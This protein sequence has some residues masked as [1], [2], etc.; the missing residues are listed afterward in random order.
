MT[1]GSVAPR[2]DTAVSPPMNTN[3][4]PCY[5]LTMD[6]VNGAR[7]RNAHQQFAHLPLE[8]KFVIGVPPG[9]QHGSG[10]Y[11][12][13]RNLARMKRSMTPGE[14]SCYHGHRKIWETMLDDGHDMALVFEDDFSVV[15]RPALLHAID[16]ATLIA[17]RWDVVKF[18]DFSTKPVVCSRRVNQ[19]EFVYH[20]YPTSGCVAYLIR[21]AVAAALLQRQAIFRPI[22]EDWSHPWE[23]GLRLLS[24]VPNP[25]TEIAIGLGGSLL[26]ADRKNIRG[27]NRNWLRTIHGNILA[28]EKRIRSRRWQQ[29]MRK[30]LG[31]PSDAPP[32][33]AQQTDRTAA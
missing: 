23:S 20:K 27:T 10:H 1:A 6:P 31:G 11:S 28:L 19:T 16:N 14:V 33:L 24:V 26:D 25:V 13:W 12:P 5:V 29:R 8:W 17:S 32:R 22:D 3:R 30:V 2:E 4:P 7:R 9:N 21:A 15:D 18:F